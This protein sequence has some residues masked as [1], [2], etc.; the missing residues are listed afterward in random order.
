MNKKGES[1]ITK[2]SNLPPLTA[3]LVD[4]LIDGIII[5]D[6]G[7]RITNINRAVTKQTGYQK[8]EAIGKNLA[9]IFLASKK[10]DKFPAQK[11]ALVAGKTI[12]A[13]ELT[14]VRQNGTRFPVSLSLSLLKDFAGKPEAIIAV[15]RDITKHKQLE[16]ELKT[17]NQQLAKQNKKLHGINKHL[18]VTAKDIKANNEKLQSLIRELEQVSSQSEGLLKNM[19]DGLGVLD[20]A[21]RVTEV[22]DALLE[23]FK[24]KREEILG[25]PFTEVLSQMVEDQAVEDQTIKQLST[26]AWQ[27]VT[28]V[29]VKPLEMTFSIK[30]N[31]KLTLSIAPGIIKD[32]QGNPVMAFGVLR[33]ITERKKLEIALKDKNEQLKAQNEKLRTINEKLQTTEDELRAK[34][35]KLEAAQEQLI[36]TEKLAAIGQMA[37]GVGHELRNPLGAIKNALYYVKEKVAKSE[38]VQQ[39]PRI[40]EF[41]D[42]ADEEINQSNKIINDLLGFARVGKP[43]TSPIRIEQIIETALAYP[44]I[45]ANIKVSKEIGTAL[46][47]VEIDANQIGQ[48]FI[49][50]IT[51]ATQAMPDGG[52][53]TIS[54]SKNGEFMEIDFADT[55]CGMNQET[56]SKIFDPLFTTKAKGIGLG[57]AVSKA[58]IDRHGGEIDVKS[59]IGEGTTFSIKLPIKAK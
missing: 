34:N 52:K 4:A 55:G 36:R 30:D 27:I 32:T 41:L 46:P 59:A 50:I 44:T 6:M 17:E 28:G 31:Q 29:P 43:T 58:I 24:L 42:I 3:T 12:A 26:V 5:T 57:L 16:E 35:E 19:M 1:A 7:G 13:A 23:M 11:A 8:Q 20:Q 14:A 54:A 38:L 56:M 53:L 48:V 51:N 22:N 10:G 45:P 18:E 9:E 49:N 47:E 2:K 39:E 37:G 33:D 40:K 25:L 15:S 21:G